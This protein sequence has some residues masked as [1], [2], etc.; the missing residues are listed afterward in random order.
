MDNHEYRVY[1]IVKAT[2]RP[3]DPTGTAKLGGRWNS[4]GV[5]AIYCSE[6]V[7]GCL[8]ELLVHLTSIDLL[9]SDLE[10]WEITVPKQLVSVL[11]TESLPETW[12]KEKKD[13]SVTQ[14]LGDQL[15]NNKENLAILVPSAVVPQ[16]MNIVLN[17]AHSLFTE[18]TGAAK[19]IDIAV[20]ERLLPTLNQT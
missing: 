11:N 6:C 9:P 15:L 13:Y 2:R 10:L 18:I 7:S 14:A 4:K 8:L 1:R 20:D 19:R 12:Q 3:F 5:E 17:P 16:D